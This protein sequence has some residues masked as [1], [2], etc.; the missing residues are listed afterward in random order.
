M[1]APIICPGCGKGLPTRA[2]VTEYIPWGVVAGH[3]EFRGWR[4]TE[5]HDR[6]YEPFCTLRCALNYA[7]LEFRRTGTRYTRRKK[8]L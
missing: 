3:H 5:P 7:R 8:E 2:K 4:P 1:T 6:P